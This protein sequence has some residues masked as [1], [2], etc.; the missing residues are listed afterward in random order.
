MKRY[1]L[2]I[3]GLL[4]LAALAPKAE[5][6]PR[7]KADGQVAYPRGSNS[8]ASANLN[9]YGVAIS[10][11]DAS[12]AATPNSAAAFTDNKTWSASAGQLYGISMGSAAAVTDY[13]IC[14]DTDPT[15]VTASLVT[16][17]ASADATLN[18]VTLCS[19]NATL[20]A[21]CAAGGSGLVA[22]TAP[23]IAYSK[24]LVCAANTTK[25]YAPLFR[26]DR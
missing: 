1:L 6:R 5:A 16:L 12:G 10:S 24:G 22:G 11:E 14:I 23:P 2:G 15:K 8:Q 9:Q 7:Q 3:V 25:W 4:C 18:I 20:F 17:W 26:E 21:Y 19:R 13:V